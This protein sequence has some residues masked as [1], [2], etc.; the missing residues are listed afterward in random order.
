MSSPVDGFWRVGID[1]GGTFTDGVMWNPATGV[2]LTAKVLSTPDDLSLGFMEALNQLF[3]KQGTDSCAIDYVAHGTT[4]ATNAVLEGKLAP[5]ALVTTAGFRDVLEIA[6][7]VRP[8]PYDVFTVKPKPLVPRNWCLEVEERMSGEGT[9]L[10]PLSLESVSAIADRLRGSQIAAIAVC[11]LH[12][13][14]NPEH[15]QLLGAALEQMLPDTPITLSSSLAPEFREYPRACTTAINAGLI[16]TIHEYLARVESRLDV[17]KV[18]GERRVM[19]SNGGLLSF[20]QARNEPVKILESG[21]AAGLI[22]AAR[23]SQA[24][25]RPMVISFDMGGTTAK[26]GLV[27]DGNA[28]MVPELEVGVESRSR[29]WF[30]GASGYPVLTPSVDLVEIGAGGGSIAWV[31]GGGKLRVGPV[32]AGASPGPACYGRGGV[33][34]TVTDANVVLGRMNPFGLLGGDLEIDSRAAFEVVSRLAETLGCDANAAALGILDIASAAMARAAQTISVER[35][36][37]PRD[38]ALAAF[39]GA[40]P[41]HAA[42]LAE[43]LGISE[44]IVQPRPGIASAIGLLATDLRFELSKTWL[45]SADRV[46]SEEL[47]NVFGSLERAACS[48]L[49]NEAD[50]ITEVRIIK[51]LDMRYEGQSYQLVV[52]LDTDI[53]MEDAIMAAQQEFH[54]LHEKRYGHAEPSEPV[55]VVNVRLSAIGVLRDALS[56]AEIEHPNE[57]DGYPSSKRNVTFARRMVI[58]TPVYERANLPVGWHLVGPAVIEENDSTTLVPPGWE[59]AVQ[60]GANL[61][62]TRAGSA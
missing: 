11:L 50:S 27:R 62:I 44:I 7:Q 9:V 14:A 31:D 48:A 32:S 51:A 10:K 4:A 59:V 22:G 57:G 37:D 54:Q 1:I 41:L 46:S 3:D 53:G 17:A 30:T 26:M 16:P 38:F 40:G 18:S 49:A 61:L 35:G 42:Q 47:F 33:Q 34:P 24:L 28:E 39:G 13:Y 56:E 36:Y 45:R 12:S 29:S 20:E 52:P 58:E 60:S 2:Q 43:E 23:I 5:I 19:Q 6:R 55:E 15:E 21:P 25:E 8:D